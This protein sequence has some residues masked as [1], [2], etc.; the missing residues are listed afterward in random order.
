MKVELALFLFWII[1]IVGWIILFK[2]LKWNDNRRYK[3][4]NDKGR[5]AEENRQRLIAA[6]EP[7]TEKPIEHP[8]PSGIIEGARSVEISVPDTT[9]TDKSEPRAPGNN[10]GKTRRSFADFFRRKRS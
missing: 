8:K 5:L 3:P 4:E 6:G 10:D 1:L 9:P 7:A 2:F